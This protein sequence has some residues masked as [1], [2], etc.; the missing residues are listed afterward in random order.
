MAADKTLAPALYPPYIEAIRIFRDLE[1]DL[2]L[3]GLF[4]PAFHTTIPDYAYIYGVPY[5]WYEQHGIR[6]YGFHGASHRYISERVPELTGK[7]PDGLKLVSCH[8]GGCSSRCAIRDGQS[9]DTTMGFSPQDGVINA[10]RNGSIDP[11]IIPHVMDAE[12][13][14]TDEIREVL[15]NES[16]LLGISGISGDLRD[17]QS[18]EEE[19]NDRARLAIEA[20]CYSIRREIGA[21]VT[22]ID[23]LD[24]LAF[25]GGIG[26]RSARVRSEVCGGLSHLGVEIAPDLNESGE[27]EREISGPNASVRTFTIPADEEKIVARAVAEHLGSE[28]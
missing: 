7:S 18:A 1:P 21:M 3:I 28:S 22:A 4:E 8:L 24:V 19:G 25:T 17:L 27:D 9:L 15:H 26:E 16:G 12:G 13:L 14:S 5:A 20:Y 10:T 23:G 2:K 11:F 6:K